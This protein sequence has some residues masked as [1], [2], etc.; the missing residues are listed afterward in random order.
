MPQVIAMRGADAGGERAVE[1]ALGQRLG[2][3]RA[4]DALAEHVGEAEHD[5]GGHTYGDDHRAREF[6]RSRR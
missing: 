4:Q 1:V 6:G 3:D 2:G 5:G